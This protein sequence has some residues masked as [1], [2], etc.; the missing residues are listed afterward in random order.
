MK[1]GKYVYN[2]SISLVTE[3]RSLK[4]RKSNETLDIN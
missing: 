1:R 3:G 2:E 4:S